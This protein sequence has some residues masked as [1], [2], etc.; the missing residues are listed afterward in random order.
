MSA[1]AGQGMVTGT[2]HGGVECKES[3]SGVMVFG[4]AVLS[5]LQSKCLS[6]TLF[7]YGP[8]SL[9][10]TIPSS[11]TKTECKGDSRPNVIKT[12][13]TPGFPDNES[14]SILLH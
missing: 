2:G 4:S 5:L 7:H 11:W 6:P 1:R 14:G 12:W 9:E 8:G 13:T 10:A 3:S